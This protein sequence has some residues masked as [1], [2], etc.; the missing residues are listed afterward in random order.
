[1]TTIRPKPASGGLPEQPFLLADYR[2]WSERLKQVS[3]PIRLGVLLLLGED[4]LHV[5]ALRTEIGCS[6]SVLSRHL[7]L[8]RFADLV[9]RRRDG[10]K[11][12]YALTTSGRA[13]SWLVR[14]AGSKHNPR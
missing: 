4:D 9:Q 14:K 11:N 7:S 2:R 6:M 1:M 8:L 5:G 12:V 13:L 3:D 10:Q